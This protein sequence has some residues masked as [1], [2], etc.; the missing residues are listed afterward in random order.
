MGDKGSKLDIFGWVPAT[1]DSVDGTVKEFFTRTITLLKRRYSNYELL[2]I[3]NGVADDALEDLTSLLKVHP[4]IRVI[5]LS[6]NY[7]Q[8]V[9]TFAALES[10]IGDYTIMV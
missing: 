8:E 10:T 1:I 6:R 9:A 7:N 2:I 5:R 3:A 4:C